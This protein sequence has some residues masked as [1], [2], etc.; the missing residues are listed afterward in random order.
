MNVILQIR[1]KF[2]HPTDS[3]VSPPYTE[4]KRWEHLQPTSKLTF[5]VFAFW[6]PTHSFQAHDEKSTTFARRNK[7]PKIA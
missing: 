5:I 2:S 7:E 3:G 1:V 6:Q 4:E